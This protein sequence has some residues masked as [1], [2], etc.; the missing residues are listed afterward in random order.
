MR[1]PLERARIAVLRKTGW[2]LDLDELADLLDWYQERSIRSMEKEI[3]RLSG[4]E[5]G[6][7]SVEATAQIDELEIVIAARRGLRK[8]QP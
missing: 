4:G 7:D 6:G 5:Y 2:Y 8:R 3:S 1:T